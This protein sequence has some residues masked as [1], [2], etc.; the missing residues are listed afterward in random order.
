M[1]NNKS[2]RRRVAAITAEQQQLLG[3]LRRTVLV[4]LPVWLVYFVSITVFDR[5][6]GAITVPYVDMPLSTYLVALGCALTFPIL[7]VML[8]RAVFAIHRQ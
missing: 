4:M 7:L 1:I 5:R 3:A 6:L 2:K 8:T